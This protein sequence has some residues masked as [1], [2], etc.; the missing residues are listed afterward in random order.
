MIR[1][2]IWLILSAVC[3]FSIAAAAVDR[4]LADYST[5]EE[6]EEFPGGLATS[7]HAPGRNSFS[8]PSANMDASKGLDFSVGNGFFKK[9][10][11]SGHTATTASDG[12]GPLY[13]ARSCAACHPGRGRG[14]PHLEE[15]PDTASVSLMLH[16]STPL[17]GSVQQRLLES[18]KQTTIPEPVYG[19]QLQMLAVP[20]HAGEGRVDIAYSAVHVDLAGSETVELRQPDYTIENPGYGEMQPDTM[21]SPRIA[22]QLIGLG[23]LDAVDEETLLAWADAE[24]ADGDGISGKPNRVWSA[25]HQRVVVGRFGHKAAKPTLNAQ[26]QAAFANDIGISVPLYPW[27]WG[28]CSEFQSEC[29]NANHGI[30]ARHDGLEAGHKVTDMVA[31][32]LRNLAVPKRRGATDQGVLAGKQLFHDAGCPVCHRPNYRTAVIEGQPEQSSQRIWPYTDLL[33][34]DMGEGLA[35]H[36]PEG[37]ANGREWRTAPLWGI[38]LTGM[39]SEH[40]YFLHDGRARNLQEAILWHGGE[41]LAARNNYAALKKSERAKLL[42]FVGSL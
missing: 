2:R 19:G 25:E 30:D 1:M 23:L 22:P 5:L 6:G 39:V 7:L 17:Q 4:E 27:A 18:R 42:K 32:Y 29:R 15:S 14:R 40:S 10:W 8:H 34:H 16:L 24:D 13:N 33:L 21:L 31:F 12:L 41:A 11:I 35:D 28:D 20:G 3:G 26:S 38:G 37:D 9:L 36:R